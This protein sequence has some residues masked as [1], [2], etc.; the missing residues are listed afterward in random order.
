MCPRALGEGDIADL[1]VDVCAS[2]FSP[3]NDLPAGL[4][5]KGNFCRAEGPV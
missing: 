4:V 5:V 3:A 2:K 1:V